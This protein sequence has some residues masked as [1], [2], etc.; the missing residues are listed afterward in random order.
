MNGYQN[1]LEQ[2]IELQKEIQEILDYIS[3]VEFEAKIEALRMDFKGTNL[4]AE[5]FK[6]VL[7]EANLTIEEQL[8]NLEAVRLENIKIAK[9]EF[10][11]TG[12]RQGI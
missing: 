9:M 8:K 6:N 7:K 10:D 1:K 5:S 3:T 12:N 11:K 2:A 4:T